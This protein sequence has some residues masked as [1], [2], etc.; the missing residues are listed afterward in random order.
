[1]GP[2]FSGSGPCR[3]NQY[4]AVLLANRNLVQQ[5]KVNSKPPNAFYEAAVDPQVDT[6]VDVEVTRP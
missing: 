5:T 3:P 4:G 1:M 2:D 6:W